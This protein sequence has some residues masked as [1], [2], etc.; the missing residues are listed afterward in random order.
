MWRRRW[1]CVSM[2]LRKVPEADLHSTKRENSR[3]RQQVLHLQPRRSE[4]YHWRQENGDIEHHVRRRVDPEHHDELFNSPQSK[5][6]AFCVDLTIPCASDREAGKPADEGEC[7]APESDD[8][9][10]HDAYPSHSSGFED[11]QELKQ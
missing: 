9:E 6:V 2:I 3:H 7:Y 5:A 1:C 4:D 8:D 11:A 10:K